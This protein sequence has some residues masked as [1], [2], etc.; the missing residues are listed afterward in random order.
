MSKNEKIIFLFSLA[1]LVFYF[2][3]LVLAPS[4]EDFLNFLTGAT[5]RDIFVNVHFFFAAIVC[6]IISMIQSLFLIRDKD[7]YKKIYFRKKV[8]L[9]V[10]TVIFLIITWFNFSINFA[11]YK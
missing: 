5:T 7:Y 11:I 10:P 9:W 1:G 4:K 6:F 8:L 2:F 3:Y